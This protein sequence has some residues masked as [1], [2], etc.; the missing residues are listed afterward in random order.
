MLSG[1]SLMDEANRN[2]VVRI[3]RSLTCSLL[4]L[5]NQMEW[6]PRIWLN[7]LPYKDSLLL[8][9]RYLQQ[10]VMNHLERSFDIE[11]NRA[12][13]LT[14]LYDRLIR[15][16]QCANKGSTDQHTYIQ[17]L[18]EGVH[19][20]F[21]TFI[22]VLRDRSPGH[23][24][25][26]EPGV[27]CGDYLFGMLQGTHSALYANSRESITVTVQEVNPRSV[28]AL[29]A[30]YERAVG[31][32]ACLVNI[33]AYHQPGVEA[34]KK[35]AGEVLTLQKRVLAVLNEASCKKPVESLTLEEIAYRC[36]EP[37]QIE[38]IYKIISHM[39]A[40]DRAIIAEGSCGS[41]RSIKVYLGECQ[42]D[43]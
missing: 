34:G 6:V 33:N 14:T 35:A 18:R 12:S 27:T 22:E 39:A 31:I 25:E 1:A 21:V 4:V 36:H 37:E 15:V 19:N 2:T 16:L 42:V 13:N 20:F 28:G 23:D 3:T 7:F 40:N 11:G 9:S 32:Y 17:Q 8:F 10:L 43:L 30:L 38:M 24:W 5:G 26:L 29:I 41:P